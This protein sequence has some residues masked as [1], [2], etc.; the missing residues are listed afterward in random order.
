MPHITNPQGNCL[1]RLLQEKLLSH[2]TPRQRLSILL[3]AAALLA[4]MSLSA[5]G[6][7]AKPARAP[8]PR[9]SSRPLIITITH[10]SEAQIQA[11]AQLKPGTKKQ[12]LRYYV[13]QRDVVTAKLTGLFPVGARLHALVRRSG[14]RGWEVQPGA[15]QVTNRAGATD[16]KT[17]VRFGNQA[18]EGEVFD[19]ELV[20]TREPL[21]PGIVPDEVISRN[22]IAVS[23]IM[24]VRRRIL[25]TPVVWIPY[26]NNSPV[27]GTGPKEVHLQAAVEVRA[28]KLPQE[29]LIG[30]VVQPTFPFTEMRWVMES[31]LSNSE[32]II[33]AFFGRRGRD[34]FSQFEIIAFIA[35][36]EDFPPRGQPIP[37]DAWE[38]MRPKFLA[39]SRVVNVVRWEGE[40]KITELNGRPTLA[41]GSYAT[42]EQADVNGTVDRHLKDGEKIWLVCLPSSRKGLPWIAGWTSILQPAGRWVINA[43]KLWNEDRGSDVV[44][45]VA[46]LAIA[47]ANAIPREELRSWVYHATQATKS[48]RLAV[49]RTSA[50]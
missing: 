3:G 25:G 36:Q 38:H 49:T 7:R 20:A 15:L 46:V 40:F 47:D 26:V 42:D 48:V 50:Q 6:Q 30:L 41:R 16:W 21:P 1:S 11:A 22:T 23:N 17:E 39:E 24:Q 28:R 34:D 37:Q 2:H 33:N 44:D 45:I 13:N 18:D 43:T 27:Y 8:T 35:W 4:L 12:I 14:G 5:A 19:L 29:S 31:S 32:G 9:P 10:I